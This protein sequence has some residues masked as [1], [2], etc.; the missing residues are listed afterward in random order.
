MSPEVISAPEL[1][2]HFISNLGRLIQWFR[3]SFVSHSRASKV[4]CNYLSTIFHYLSLQNTQ[5][6]LPQYIATTCH[7]LSNQCRTTVESN[8]TNGRRACLLSYNVMQIY[9]SYYSQNNILTNAD[10]CRPD[11]LNSALCSLSLDTV[12]FLLFLSLSFSVSL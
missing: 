10:S 4:H 11:F 1:S 6:H 12:I 8:A 5:P 2:L 7:L 3:Q 9:L